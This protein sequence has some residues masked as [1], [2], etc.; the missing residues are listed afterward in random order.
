[1]EIVTFFYLE[2]F[3]LQ[4]FKMQGRQI[5][6]IAFLILIAFVIHLPTVNATV[7]K[8]LSEDEMASQAQAI[9]KG[10]CTSIKSEWNEEG[11]KIFTYITISPQ[12]FLKDDENSQTIVIKQPGGEVGEIGMRV[13]GASVF[14][15]GE[16]VFLFLKRG[17]KGFHRILGLSQGKFSIK[18]DPVTRR[19]IL[20][21]KGVKRVRNPN[22]KMEKLI[23]EIKSDKKIILDEF[24]D[25]IQNIL[26]GQKE[27]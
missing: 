18:T 11:T 23:F 12:E 4:G 27:R 2:A 9:V 14:E 15:E 5:L 8:K 21:K 24:T 13:D 6:K 26:Q 7:V 1:M 3:I 25:R 17:R 16:E 10:T 22:G 19:R 20:F